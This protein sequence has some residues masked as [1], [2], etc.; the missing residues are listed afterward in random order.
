MPEISKIN[1]THDALI[2]AI[3][4]NPEMTQRQFA[5][6]FGYTESWLSVVMNSDAFQEKLAERKEEIVNPILRASI[7]DRLKAV[8]QTSLDNILKQMTL[9]P[10]DMKT[11][12]KA[13]ELSTRALGYGAKAPQTAVQVNI[14]PVAVVPAK[15]VSS[16]EWM[17]SFRPGA[18]PQ[19]VTFDHQ[20]SEDA[21]P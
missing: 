20:D 12:T 3:I 17:Q 19:P 18:A 6:V 7:E 1:Y 9:Q 8:A 2:D 4:A 13:L 16:D 21:Q 14:A 11:A 10:A 15:S 5:A